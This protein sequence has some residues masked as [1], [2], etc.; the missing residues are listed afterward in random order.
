M[1]EKLAAQMG[2]RGSD[3]F[4][5]ETDVAAARSSRIRFFRYI[6][7]LASGAEASRDA[8]EE[9]VDLRRSP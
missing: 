4:S 3:R 1:V 8:V 9:G 7:D 2:S 6:L 5:L